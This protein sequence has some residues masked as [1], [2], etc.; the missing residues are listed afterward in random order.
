MHK[1]ESCKEGEFAFE[2]GEGGDPSP[3][4]QVD[5]TV[6]NLYFPCNYYSFFLIF[7]YKNPQLIQ[8][9]LFVFSET[10]FI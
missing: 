6:L 5:F 9:I 10:E 4:N 1:L 7:Y 2:S 8:V 3:T